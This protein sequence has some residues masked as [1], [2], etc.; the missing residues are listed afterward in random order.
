ME[1]SN[2]LNTEISLIT[3]EDLQILKQNLT[4]EFDEFW[5]YSILETEV[6]NE[7]T[8]YIVA[9]QNN[10][11]VGFAGILTILDEANIMNIVTKKNKRH[12]GIGSLLLS[13]LIN[14][15][16]KKNLKSITLEVNENNISAMNLYTKFNF[17][18]VGERKKY[19]N[20]TDTALLMTLYI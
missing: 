18:K 9:K 15:S 17:E 6:N 11:I 10:E 8:T 14:I 3:P 4:T 1:K 2:N 7:N 20:N 19:Y 16:K 12:S 5:S 13:E